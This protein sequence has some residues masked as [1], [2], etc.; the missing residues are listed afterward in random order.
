[1]SISI[2]EADKCHICN[3]VYTHKR[4]NIKVIGDELPVVIFRT[5][6][7]SCSRVFNKLKIAK[8][9]LLEAEWDLFMLKY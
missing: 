1:M 7:A 8:D 5:C 4:Y 2:C 9:A 3:Q 6:H